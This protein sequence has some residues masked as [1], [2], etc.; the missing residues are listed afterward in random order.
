MEPIP[1]P[2]NPFI[3]DAGAFAIPSFDEWF[4]LPGDWLIYLL[5]SRAPAAAELLRIGP[6]EYG[7]TL[8]GLF[9]W[10][11]WIALAVAAIVA[12]SALRRFDRAL[13]GHIVGAAVEVRRRVR[14]AIAFARYR[15]KARGRRKEPAF[16]VG[17]EPSLGRDELRALELHAKLAPGFALAVSDIAE[18]LDA[19]VHEVRAALERLQKL[20][21]LQSTVGGLDGETAYTLTA[22]GGALLQMRHA[23]PRTA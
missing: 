12:T 19:R 11:C 7:G 8:A 4:F 13:T 16:D 15:R 21:L 14:M 5:A 9:A 1:T 2:P 6:A 10:V 17:E 3:A 20:Q 22:A 18:E 23:R